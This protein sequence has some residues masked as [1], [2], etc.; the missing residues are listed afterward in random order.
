MY[1]YLS[2][3]ALLPDQ[4]TI[5][6]I[7]H[8]GLPENNIFMIDNTSFEEIDINTIVKT[9]PNCNFAVK[10]AILN[11]EK[12]FNYNKKNIQVLLNSLTKFDSFDVSLIQPIYI[13][14]KKLLESVEAYIK[15]KIKLT[16]DI[17]PKMA[18]LNE[19]LDDATR[20]SIE[21]SG[22]KVF[23]TFEYQD[24]EFRDNE[25]RVVCSRCENN[26][27]QCCHNRCICTPYATDIQKCIVFAGDQSIDGQCGVCNHSVQYHCHSQQFA[28]IVEKKE[29]K[30]DEHRKI[31]FDE[32]QIK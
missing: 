29:E 3:N 7:N 8:L 17:Y 28:I 14:N 4:D 32:T 19:Q 21:Y 9:I 16:N 22:Y 6:V 5:S 23:T 18:R 25:C 24:F 31:I 13:I 2:Q 20:K 27:S 12:S 1:N 26:E 10:R 11:Q 15:Y 30:Y